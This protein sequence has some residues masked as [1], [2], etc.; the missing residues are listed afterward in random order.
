MSNQQTNNSGKNTLGINEFKTNMADPKNFNFFDSLTGQQVADI[1]GVSYQS[2]AQYKDQE[3]TLLQWV[4]V[5]G[6]VLYTR[7]SV[8][9]FKE[10][11]DAQLAEQGI[12]GKLDTYN[13]LSAQI[14]KL[15]ERMNKAI[16]KRDALKLTEEQI[17]QAKAL[18]QKEES[19]IEETE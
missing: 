1:L 8:E 4:R 13:K 10:W 7:E 14:T 6:S 2:V 19:A 9:A 17:E 16:A 3:G 5:G 18:P 11:R 12:N 15:Q